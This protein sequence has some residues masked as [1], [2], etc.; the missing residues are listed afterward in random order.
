M[1][2]IW[3]RIN[4]SKRKIPS[5]KRGE[6]LYFEKDSI[7]EWIKSGRRKILTRVKTGTTQG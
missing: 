2:I 3:G 7:D 5:I 6:R 1:F 4:R